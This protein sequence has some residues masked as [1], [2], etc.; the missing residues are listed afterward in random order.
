VDLSKRRVDRAGDVLRISAGGAAF[1]EDAVAE[2]LEIAERFRVAHAPTLEL[3]A[4]ELDTLTADMNAWR[5]VGRR[6]KRLDT[7]QGKLMREPT[8]RLSRMR[9]IAGCRL[10]VPSL[11]HLLEARDRVAFGISGEVVR[12]VDYVEQPRPSGYRGVHIIA[13]YDEL[14]AEFQIRTQLMHR[15][16]Q[17]SEVV[18]TLHER[19]QP[20]PDNVEIARWLWDYAQGLAHRDKGETIPLELE[21]RIRSLPIEVVDALISRGS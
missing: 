13:R 7:I 15:W 12:V 6:L 19:D 5:E 4:L 11:Q 16:A 10:T 1:D 17:L 20:L 14:L 9:D 18:Q 3:S 2:A 8:L 21:R